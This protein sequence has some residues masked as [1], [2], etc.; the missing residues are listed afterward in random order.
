MVLPKPAGGLPLALEVG[1]IPVGDRRLN[2]G[3]EGEREQLGAN[4]AERIVLFHISG[5]LGDRRGGSPGG[6]RPLC[7]SAALRATTALGK[8]TDLVAGRSLEREASEA[9]EHDQPNQHG[10][11]KRGAPLRPR[12]LKTKASQGLA[13]ARNDR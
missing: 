1:A 9:E 13:L 11:R 4:R 2:P 8:R 5:E 3:D 6:R 10:E 12:R 7:P